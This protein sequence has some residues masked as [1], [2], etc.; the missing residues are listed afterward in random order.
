MAWISVALLFGTALGVSVVR[1]RITGVRHR[2]AGCEQRTTQMAVEFG[3]LE[4][5]RARAWRRE[6][7]LR[8]WLAA[9]A[10]IE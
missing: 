3:A 6:V 5:E 7:L 1:A 8:R 9:T 2:L 4:R 10:A